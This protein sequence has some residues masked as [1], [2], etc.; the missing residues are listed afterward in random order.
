MLKLTNFGKK[1]TVKTSMKKE[2]M[3]GGFHMAFFSHG[4]IN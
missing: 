4:P 3:L 1:I 2:K